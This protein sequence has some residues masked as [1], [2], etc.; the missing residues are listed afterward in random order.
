MSS[1]CLR[2]SWLERCV[3]AG[4]SASMQKL[5]L[6]ARARGQSHLNCPYLF[7][8]SD[9][10]FSAIVPITA[11]GAASCSSVADGVECKCAQSF[12]CVIGAICGWLWCPSL[13]IFSLFS[14]NTYSAKWTAGTTS[15]V[16][17]LSNFT[18]CSKAWWVV[19]M[20]STEAKSSEVEREREDK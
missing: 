2:F 10:S 9:D 4:L 11:C 17:S 15:V 18:A 13:F 12:R 1:Q 19:N 5:S 14:E 6:F 8:M 3:Q 16:M 7:F 20:P